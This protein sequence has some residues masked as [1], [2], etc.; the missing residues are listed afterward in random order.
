MLYTNNYDRVL[1]KIQW[2]T[3]QTHRIYIYAQ[4]RTDSLC[5]VSLQI[6]KETKK[7]RNE[8]KIV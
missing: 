2:G 3:H 7:K 6:Y 5:H 1:I 4:M 8:N